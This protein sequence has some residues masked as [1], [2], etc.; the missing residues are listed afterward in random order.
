MSTAVLIARAIL[1]VVF[2]AA[3][4]TKL[5]DLRTTRVSLLG[6]GVS[7]R[8]A[9]AAS[10][11]L[12]L[13][14][15][16]VA[17]TLVPTGTAVGA[18]TAAVIMLAA[19]NAAIGLAL[20]RGERPECNCFGRIHSRPVGWPELVRNL[21]LAAVAGT[22]ALTG[23]GEAV[24]VAFA[25]VSPLAVAGGVLLALQAW[26]SYQ[27]FRQNGRLIGRVQVLEEAIETPHAHAE[28]ARGL[29]VGVYAPSFSIADMDGH[30]RTLDELLAPGLPLAL[31][32]SDPDCGACTSLLPRLAHWRAQRAGELTVALVTRGG[33]DEARAGLDGHTFDSILLQ[34]RRELAAAYRVNAV[35][36]VVVVDVHGQ[37][38]SPI[39]TGETAIAELLGPRG[40]F[41]VQLAR[42]AA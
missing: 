39:T 34:Q 32:F 18:G 21:L 19:F 42:A 2:A 10:L 23:P 9:P 20:A 31:V 11:V 16:T 27:L 28:A 33:A 37:I 4:A 13:V 12:P 15:L 22:V 25:G 5:A 40:V 17:V 24:G 26:F 35:P 29:E 36:S 1:A 14:E 8:L 41:R 6:F 30:R 7:V 38:A 3:G